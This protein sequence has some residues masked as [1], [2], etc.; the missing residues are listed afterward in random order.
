MNEILAERKK[1]RDYWKFKQWKRTDSWKPLKKR[2]RKKWQTSPTNINFKYDLA[3]VFDYNKFWKKV[4]E[5]P[6]NIANWVQPNTP[7]TIHE[8]CKE[9][10]ITYSAF[11]GRLRN[12][13]DLK[14]YWEEMKLA[15]REYSKIL[16]HNNIERAISWEM[17]LTDKEKT[18]FS[19]RLLEKTE[20]AFNPKV[21]IEQK[22]INI[23]FNKST[24]DL[25]WE[26][27]ELLWNK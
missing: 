11:I 21:E 1:P 17:D 6:E 9:C 18:E 3:L 16:A 22:G 20:Q 4:I 5:N 27:Q 24:E 10:W 12:R 26:L 25:V 19:F 8:A 2:W 7:M 23:N 14:E 13:P 15:S